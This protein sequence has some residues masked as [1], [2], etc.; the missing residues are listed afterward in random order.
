M[1][2]TLVWFRLDLRLDDH[3]ALAAAVARGEPIIPVFIWAPEEEGP[4]QPGAASRWWLHQ[5]LSALD[6]DLRRLGSRLIVREGPTLT[7]LEKLRARQR[8]APFFGA[9]VTSRPSFNETRP[10]KRP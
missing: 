4:W 7:E 1:S 8:P 9:V 6:A 2:T 3:P 10:S 5:S